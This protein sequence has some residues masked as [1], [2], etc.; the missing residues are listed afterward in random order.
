MR[1]RRQTTIPTLVRA[2]A[3]QMPKSVELEQRIARVELLL[4]DLQIALEVQ[5]NRTIAIQAQ[6]DHID[7]RLSYR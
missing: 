3:D 5:T 6:L 4:R 7:A 2:T 1:V